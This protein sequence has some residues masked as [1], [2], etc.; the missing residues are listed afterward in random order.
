MI[1]TGL[2]F[3]VGTRYWVNAPAV[4]MRPILLPEY[5]VNQSAPSGPLVMPSGKLFS[6]GMGYSVS[7]PA[8][9]MRPI[10]SPL[11]SVNQSAPSGPGATQFGPL[12]AVGT[13]YSAM[14]ICC[15]GDISGR[16]RRHAARQAK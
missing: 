5:S 14:A 3:A 11:N 6:V 2:P 4:V 9:V 13:A 8:V 1:S 12:D 16:P 7:A 15:A 10:L